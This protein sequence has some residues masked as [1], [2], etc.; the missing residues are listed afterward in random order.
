MR[1]FLRT[2]TGKTICHIVVLA[3][4]LP[5]IS[6]L[7]S[8]R[9]VA[10]IQVKPQWAVVPFVNGQPGGGGG[11]YGNLAAQSV[12]DELGKTQ[13]YDL[14]PIESVV[15]TTQSLSLTTPVTDPTSLLRLAQELGVTTLV[16]G[17]MVGWTIKNVGGGKQADVGIQVT[18]RDVASGLPVNGAAIEATSAVRSSSTPQDT[19]IQE[20]L[21]QASSQAVSKIQSQ[22]LPNATVLNTRNNEGLIN[23]GA[24]DG[25]LDGQQ[26]IV[27]RAREEVATA[28]I[29]GTEPDS[30]NIRIIRQ[31]KGIQPGDKVRVVFAVPDLVMTGTPGAGNN[32][33][34]V[35]QAPGHI[36]AAAVIST[37]L[38]LG[39]VAFLLTGGRSNSNNAVDNVQ[40]Q[41]TV[42]PTSSGNPVIQISW[43]LDPFYRNS[44]NVQW[45]IFRNDLGPSPAQVQTGSAGSVFDDTTTKTFTAATN[46]PLINSLTCINAPGDQSFTGVPG[47]QVGTPY[48]Y[49]VAGVYQVLE[50]DIPGI[51]TG[52][53]ATAGATGGVTAGTTGG[54]TAGT[55][56]GVT[57]GTTGGITAGGTGG[58]TAGGTGGLTGLHQRPSLRPS[59]RPQPL[60]ATTT[61]T[62]ATTTGTTATATTTGTTQTSTGQV[63]TTGTFCYFVS[64][65]TT[66][67]GYATALGRTTAVSPTLNQSIT[68][69]VPF[70]FTSLVT[71][72]TPIT[73]AYVVQIFAGSAPLFPKSSTITSAELVS[74]DQNNLSISFQ[75]RF[76]GDTLQQ[77][78]IDHFGSTSSTV[79]WR[80]GARN[81]EDFPGPLPDPFTGLRYIFSP[82]SSFVIPT[83]TPK[84]K[85]TKSTTTTTT[86]TSHNSKGHTTTTSTTKTSATKGS[87]TPVTTAH[88]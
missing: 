43:R 20:A 35:K 16:T 26:V 78:I 22:I 13:D 41:A 8:S 84:K 77:F 48:L 42:F 76:S 69:Y 19:M 88:H 12:Y 56:G 65:T 4:V 59:F 5:F 14:I 15:T 64:A 58:I 46:E 82:A 1:R 40:A 32:K 72:N 81:V 3:M 75:P 68:S 33:F 9:V 17:K 24:R 62:T 71:A 86:T 67:V 57:A 85:K 6:Y 70:T 36:N 23:R 10:Q 45:L 47:I 55:T 25:F 83:T 79:W 30:A 27:S 38:V 52:G 63:T 28:S 34:I 11:D 29:F 18:V 53:T 39:A 7:S 44:N 74:A 2:K 54:V 50:I 37:G 49:Q 61:G 21:A 80:V 60:T 66:A 73:L 31:F 51:T 87:T